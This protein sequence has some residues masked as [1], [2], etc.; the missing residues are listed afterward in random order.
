MTTS[1]FLDM[2]VVSKHRVDDDVTFLGR[3]VGEVAYSEVPRVFDPRFAFL[4][5]AGDGFDGDA[6]EDL[7]VAHLVDLRG[8]DVAQALIP[9]RERLR[10][11]RVESAD[12]LH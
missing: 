10:E 12:D 4:D 2:S 9:V 3:H 1:N 5:T 11:A 8:E 7:V 6:V